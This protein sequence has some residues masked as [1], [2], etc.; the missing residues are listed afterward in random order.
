MPAQ[1]LQGDTVLVQIPSATSLRDVASITF[2]GA[3]VK[4]FI[5]NA[6]V[7]AFIPIPLAKKP[8]DYLLKVQLKNGQSL[9][10][11]ISV[12]VR[13]KPKEVLGIPAKFG[14]TTAATTK[15]LVN[16]LAAENKS[17]NSGSTADHTLWVAAFILP[18]PNTGITDLYGYSRQTGAY[19]IP[20]M[21]TDFRASVGTPVTAMNRG[22][23]RITHKYHTYGNTIVI[24]HGL[25]VFT[26]YLHLSKISVHVGQIVSQKEIIGYSGD[27]G[28]VSGPHLHVSVHINGVSVDPMQF[29]SLFSSR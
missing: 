10:K 25:G 20:H 17:L 23:V 24:D 19:T 26:L 11:T 29:L 9:E 3:T 6:A 2:G 13:E 15:K 16:S 7:S 5:Y 18:L 22:V 28:I 4:D 14:G 12:T 27:T 8:G 1:V 21:G